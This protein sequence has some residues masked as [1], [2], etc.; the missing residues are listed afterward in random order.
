MAI[1]FRDLGHG[2]VKVSF[3]STGEV[4]VNLFA[5]TFG[6]GGHAKAAGALIQGDLEE[7]RERVVEAAR[8]YLKQGSGGR[9]QGSGTTSR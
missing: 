1:F 4:D 9:V 3:R 7:V 8:E 6:G 5:R 2:K